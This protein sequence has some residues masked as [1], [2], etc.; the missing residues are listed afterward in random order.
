MPTTGLAA[1][2]RMAVLPRLL[3]RTPGGSFGTGTGC[4]QLR[5]VGSLARS[6][7]GFSL[8]GK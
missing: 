7:G 8:G 4:P 1:G 2:E 6:S 3:P 5:G